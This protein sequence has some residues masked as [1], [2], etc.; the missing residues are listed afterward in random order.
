MDFM[1]GS[2]KVV[3]FDGG[4]LLCSKVVQ[5]VH[6]CDKEKQVWFAALESE[7]AAEHRDLLG[8]PGPGEEAETF[9]FWDRA[10][11]ENGE[12]GKVAFKSEGTLILM[13]TLGGFWLGMA[14]LLSAFPLR[15]RDGCYD[16]VA[17][18]RRD[19]FGEDEGCSLP[20]ESLRDQMLG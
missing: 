4:C 11:G 6:Q 14:V 15:L 7:F 19:W 8:L 10:N 1:E 20:S 2:Q 9:A 17:R 13:K 12:R 16:F 3:F 5:W 18:N